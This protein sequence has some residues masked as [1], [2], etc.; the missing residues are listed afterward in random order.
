MISRNIGVQIDQSKVKL[1]GSIY[2]PRSQSLAEAGT[3]KHQNIKFEGKDLSHINNTIKNFK[4]FL[5]NEYV[6]DLKSRQTAKFTIIDYDFKMGSSNNS[7]DF[8][9]EII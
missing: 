7:N 1:I 3:I 9:R 6:K 5:Q 8:Q 4:N 2:S